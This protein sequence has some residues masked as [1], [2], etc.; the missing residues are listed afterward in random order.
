MD[1]AGTARAVTARR[2][3]IRQTRVMTVAFIE[4]YRAQWR[5][6]DFNQHMANS[7]FLDYASNTRILFFDSVGFTARTFAEL[8]IGPVVL[9]DRLVYRREVRLLEP[10]T[11]D[12][13]T[14]ALSPDGR[15]FKVRNRFTTEAQGLCATV[16]SVGLWF[17]L[18]ER[19]PVVPPADLQQAF[20][21]L[22]RADD[23]AEWP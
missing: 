20:G 5:D 7:A 15:R 19:R 10:F 12:F 9:D 22:A 4:Q 2:V 23:F 16:D 13:Q 21:A 14:L 3:S 11:V 6:M 18:V 17:D 1:D 8:R